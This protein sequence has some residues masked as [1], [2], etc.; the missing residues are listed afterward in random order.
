MNSQNSLHPVFIT[1][2]PRSGTS[3]L[4]RTLLKHSSFAPKE[5]CMEETRIFRHSLLALLDESEMQSLKKYMLDDDDAFNRF[6]HSIQFEKKWQKLLKT[7]KLPF[8]LLDDIR[9]WRFSKN[10]VVIQKYFQFAVEA[11][12][13]QRIVEKTPNHLLAYR[14]IRS[15]F[16]QAAIIVLVRHPI[17]VY[18]SYRKRLKEHPEMEWLKMSVEEFIQQYQKYSTVTDMILKLQQSYLLRYEDF[19]QFPEKSFRSLCEFLGEPFEATPI[20]EA[21]P[22]LKIEGI[23]PNLSKTIQKETK[24]WSNYLNEDEAN[25]IES[26]LNDVMVKYNYE[27]VLQGS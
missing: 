5:L 20:Q 27:S 17:E 12:G 8:I 7:I 15:T 26:A 14:R 13:C 6:L 24:V 19:V 11:R 2:H 21:E 22:S 1:A 3:L 18:S 16:P 23:N 25:Q 4:Y 9:A 10:P